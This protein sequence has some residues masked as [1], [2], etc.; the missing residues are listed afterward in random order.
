MVVW[1]SVVRSPT[2]SYESESWN[3]I[4]EPG[5]H[6]VDAESLGCVLFGLPVQGVFSVDS[7]GS[8]FGNI[9]SITLHS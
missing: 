6:L 5:E 4:L 8:A 1:V 9:H 2:Q 7:T 3:L